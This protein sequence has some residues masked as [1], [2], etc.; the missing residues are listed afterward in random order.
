M[1]QGLPSPRDSASVCDRR[2]PYDPNDAFL[3]PRYSSIPQAFPS[4]GSIPLRSDFSGSESEMNLTAPSIIRTLNP[5]LPG[6]LIFGSG[7][8]GQTALAGSYAAED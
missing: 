1:R 3:L 2:D 7:L 4:L 5:R 6:R 8:F